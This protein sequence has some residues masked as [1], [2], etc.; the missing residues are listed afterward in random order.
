M[1]RAGSKR[2]AIL[3]RITHCLPKDQIPAPPRIK[4]AEPSVPRLMVVGPDVDFCAHSDISAMALGVA[5]CG[6]ATATPPATATR[7]LLRATST[8]EP[9]RL[10]FPNIHHAEL[11]AALAQEPTLT[12]TPPKPTATATPEP[13]TP[14]PTPMATPFPPGPPSKLGLH[15][16]RKTNQLFDL[17]ATGAVS[18][19]TTLE[20]DAGLAEEIKTAAPNTKLIGRLGSLPQA[21]L[22]SHG[23]HRLGP[24][25]RRSVDAHRGR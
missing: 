11:Q 19:V 23:S 4:P 2:A 17:L 8:P 16:E 14:T 5:A 15:I 7:R 9:F 18:A 6:G 20:Y 25:L 3:I 24:R 12:P 1:S 10:Y 22:S 21:N 13:P